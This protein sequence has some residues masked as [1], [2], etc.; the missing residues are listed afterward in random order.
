MWV[1]VLMLVVS[2]MLAYVWKGWHARMLAAR[3]DARK[4]EQRGLLD[5]QDKLRAQAIS[6]S[7][8]ERIK[9]VATQ[10]LGLV[11]PPLTPID[12]PAIAPLGSLDSLAA[13]RA[14]G[15][16]LWQGAKSLAPVTKVQ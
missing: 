16:E 13:S 3:V 7:N 11:D 6:L 9:E 8:V 10:Q 2:L 4:A 14:T 1:G 5:E 15:T 12:V